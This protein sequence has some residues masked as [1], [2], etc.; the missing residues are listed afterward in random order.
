M[1]YKKGYE[2]AITQ[3]K[4]YLLQHFGLYFNVWNEKGLGQMSQKNLNSFTIR[5]TSFQVLSICPKSKSKEM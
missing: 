5:P 3:N 4:D 1:G 2:W